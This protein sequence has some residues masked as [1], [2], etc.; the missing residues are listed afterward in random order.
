M[1]IQYLKETKIG[2]IIF[3]SLLLFNACCFKKPNE[4]ARYALSEK[5]LNLIPYEINDVVYFEHSGG[6]LFEFE[7]VEDL[8][9]WRKYT[10]FCEWNCCGQDYF[11]YETKKTTL[12]SFY[13]KFEI[14]LLL[15]ENHFDYTPNTLTIDINSRHYFIMNYDSLAEI[16]II[17]NMILHDSL[18]LNDVVFKNVIEKPIEYL[19]YTN[20]SIELMP[21]SILYNQFGLLQIKM[22]NDETFTISNP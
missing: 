7:V 2:V 17:D 10:E 12:I 14:H 5:E 11:S 21:Q 4:T 19:T 1:M 16:Q 6:Y 22:N 3:L 20:D 8:I 9:E 18:I 13:P 15:G